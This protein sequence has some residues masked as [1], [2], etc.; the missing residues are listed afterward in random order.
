MELRRCLRKATKP[1]FSTT[2]KP[3]MAGSRNT[4]FITIEGNKI[5]EIEGYVGSAPKEPA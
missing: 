4:E 2:A 1:L 5:K 3:R